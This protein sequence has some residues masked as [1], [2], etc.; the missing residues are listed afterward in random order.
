MIIYNGIRSLWVED[1]TISIQVLTNFLFCISFYWNSL[2]CDASFNGYIS[3]HTYEKPMMVCYLYHMVVVVVKLS[4]F[5]V[6]EVNVLVPVAFGIHL[7][8]PVNDYLGVMCIST[9]WIIALV[10]LP[11]W[12]MVYKYTV[13]SRIIYGIP[14]PI[15]ASINPFPGAYLLLH[16][17]NN[18]WIL[19]YKL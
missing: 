8:L 3:Y 10:Y 9:G 12:Y 6:L 19:K 14:C 4:V 5:L 16:I 11:S 7:I 17:L 2:Y 13:T 1:F 15:I 18:P